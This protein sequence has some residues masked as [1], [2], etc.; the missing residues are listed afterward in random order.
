M[1]ILVTGGG[2]FVGRYVVKALVEKGDRVVIFSRNADSV[3]N[4]FK[5]NEGKIFSANG[6]IT[7]FERIL[8]V[9]RDY[10]INK[11]VHL[12]ALL[13][14]DAE[15]N[16]LLAT[17]INCIG[18]IN[19]FEVAKLLNPE[20]IVLGSSI[21]VFGP[22]EAYKEVLLSE[23]ALHLPATVYGVTKSFTEFMSN[24]YSKKYNLPIIGLRFTFVYGPGR[25]RGAGQFLQELQDKPALGQD[26]T[27]PFGDD[28]ID[29]LFVEDAAGAILLA[30]DSKICNGFYNITGDRRNVKEAADYVNKLFPD[31][32]IRLLSGKM[33][34]HFGY[35]NTKALKELGYYRK[36]S[37]EDGFKKTINF[38]RRDNGLEPIL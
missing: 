18:T 3:K 17:K 26:G 15:E 5:K 34:F 19:I 25:E 28:I 20:K 37:M 13:T 9:A 32:K 8:Q 36:W 38:I 27:V 10:E 4:L 12:S 21:A 30:L 1:N 14:S 33:P 23:D 6:D 29:W 2:G 24:Y 35:D 7:D 11:I 16:P 31:I 22:S